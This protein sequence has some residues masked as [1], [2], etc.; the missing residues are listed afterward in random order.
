VVLSH[1]ATTSGT[2]DLR[3]TLNKAGAVNTD[4]LVFQTGR[5][6]RSE[7]GLCGDD[8]LSVKISSDGA[9]RTTASKR[10]R[11]AAAFACPKGARSAKTRTSDTGNLIH[12]RIHTSGHV[13]SARLRRPPRC[14]SAARSG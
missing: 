5:S 9:A 14:M 11:M 4:S 1:D 13:G 8:N 3:V 10:K 12:L 7:I 6:G 2:G